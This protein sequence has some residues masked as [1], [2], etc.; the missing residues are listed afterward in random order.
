MKYIL[1][2]LAFII[3]A[4]AFYASATTFE[5]QECL[6]WQN[7]INEGLYEHHLSSWKVAQCEAHELGLTK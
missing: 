4:F 1:A 2:T 5:K 7:E 3:F 6:N